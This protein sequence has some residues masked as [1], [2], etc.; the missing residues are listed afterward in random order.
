MEEVV[1]PLIKEWGKVE[2]ESLSL[3]LSSLQADGVST[4]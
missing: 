4:K 2:T 1:I 3:D